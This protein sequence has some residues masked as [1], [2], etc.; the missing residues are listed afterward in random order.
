MNVTTIGIAVQIVY[1]PAAVVE[2]TPITAGAAR[3]VNRSAAEA[4]EVPPGPVTVTSTAPA[5]SAGL[6]AVICVAET[7]TTLLAASVPKSTAVAPVKPVPPIVT[8]V[9]PAKGPAELLTPVT[10]GAGMAV[11]RSAEEVVETPPGPV[12]VTSTMPADSAGLVAVICVGETTTTLLAAIVPKSTTVAPLKPTP[13][14][15]T[16]VPPAAG[17]CDGL[18]PVTVGG[19]M[20]VN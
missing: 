18:M 4:A 14:I 6:V 5:D 15:V 2:D 8:A 10:V 12:T 16:G 19:A 1:V 3:N 20:Y 17:P 7:I 11:K 13:V 9:P